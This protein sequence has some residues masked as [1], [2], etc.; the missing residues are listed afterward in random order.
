MEFN[1]LTKENSV[2]D[3]AKMALQT[4]MRQFGGDAGN[5]PVWFPSCVNAVRMIMAEDEMQGMECAAALYMSVQNK[6]TPEQTVTAIQKLLMVIAQ[7]TNS[8]SG[9]GWTI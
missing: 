3:V 4:A 6:A 8:F 2:D 9:L 1:T 7:E 5:I